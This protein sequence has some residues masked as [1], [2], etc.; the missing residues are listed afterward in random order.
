MLN[1]FMLTVF[2]IDTLFFLYII[3]SNARY[4]R[5]QLA[6]NHTVHL[7]HVAGSILLCVVVLAGLWIEAGYKYFL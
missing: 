1:I 5:K 4:A 2:S 6:Q 7:A 3:V